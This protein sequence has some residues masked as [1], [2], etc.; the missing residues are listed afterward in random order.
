MHVNRIRSYVVVGAIAVA[1]AS[2]SASQQAPPERPGR[3]GR[4]NDAPSAVEL[5]NILD[6]YAI[7]QAEHALSL[8][9]TQYMQFVT[10]LRKLQEIRRRSQRERNQVI[11]E[12]QNLT[13]PQVTGP[14]DETAVRER[15]KTLREHDERAASEIRRAYDAVDE[16]LDVRQQARF[17]IFEENI[18]RRK[19]DL[20]VRARERAARPKQETPR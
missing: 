20:L 5:M 1:G 15:L 9:D 4:A 10:R 6:A 18:E 8:S 12:L 13:G 3:A 2:A 14:I 16:V 7:V 17:R 11:R 19:L